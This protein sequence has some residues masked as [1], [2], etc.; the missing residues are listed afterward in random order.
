MA[1][2]ADGLGDRDGRQEFV[3]LLIPRGGLA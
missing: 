3:A 1:I 2:A